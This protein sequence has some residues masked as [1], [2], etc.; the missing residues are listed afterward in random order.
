MKKYSIYRN[1]KKVD[2]VIVDNKTSDIE[3]ITE[4]L[5]DNFDDVEIEDCKDGYFKIHSDSFKIKR[6]R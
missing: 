5:H 3:V 2:T 6:T 1:G 4:W